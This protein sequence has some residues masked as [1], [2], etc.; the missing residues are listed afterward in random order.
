[1]SDLQNFT[2]FWLEIQ[3]KAGIL[4]A[5]AAAAALTLRRRDAA[6]RHSVQA[7]FAVFLLLLPVLALVLPGWRLAD[8]GVPTPLAVSAIPSPVQMGVTSAEGPDFRSEATPGHGAPPVVAHSTVNPM[9][10][11]LA[12][13]LLG[14]G[15]LLIRLVWAHRRTARLIGRGVRGCVELPFADTRAWGLEILCSPELDVPALAGLRRPAILLPATAGA[16]PAERLQMVLRHEL[17][18]LQRW[19][20]VW[21]LAVDLACALY[22][23]NPLVWRLRRR[24]R[25]DSEH[26]CDDLVLLKGTRA[27]EYARHLLGIAGETKVPG[28]TGLAA[29]ASSSDLESRMLAIL[30]PSRP[31]HTRPW[32]AATAA[33]GIAAAGVAVGSWGDLQARQGNTLQEQEAPAPPQPP[34]P[35]PPPQPR[36]V[37]EAAEPPLPPPPPPPP[38]PP[39]A[40]E[41]TGTWT[42]QEG[43]AEI[44][45]HLKGVR[46]RSDYSDVESIEPGGYLDLTRRAA[47]EQRRLRIEPAGDTA[48][49]YRYLLDDRP[50]TAA[51]PEVQTL[52]QP[53]LHQIRARHADHARLRKEVE[54]FRR[55]QAKQHRQIRQRNQELQSIREEMERVSGEIGRLLQEQESSLRQEIEAQVAALTPENQARLRELQQ[56]MD[57]IRQQVAS[58]LQPR[59]KELEQEIQRIT[60]EILRESLRQ[61]LEEPQGPPESY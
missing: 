11:V 3:L 15:A 34:A 18:H 8:A 44:R 58:A 33:L 50:A 55:E 36:A 56:K 23:I 35:L 25:A 17:A 59:L 52:M 9:T 5:L 30:D 39:P 29:L 38:T 54:R 49:S 46:F 22:W 48:G 26:A 27:Q 40:P 60:E 51:D 57:L 53:L 61:T 4:T 13:W 21:Y 42:W 37:S 6:F 28:W 10:A 14:A 41:G 47:G 20:L 12:L 2:T 24:L 32:L 31:R 16:W 43:G 1:M 19:D 45:L 7:A